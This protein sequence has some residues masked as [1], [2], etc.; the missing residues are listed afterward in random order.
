MLKQACPAPQVP[1]PHCPVPQG[2]S[3]LLGA[4]IREVGV[5]RPAS[6]SQSRLQ[7]NKNS[8][9][10]QGWQILVFRVKG[11]LCTSQ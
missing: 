6:C 2:P 9:I 1:A 10:L 7:K 4:G 3:A 8:L 5:V 11:F